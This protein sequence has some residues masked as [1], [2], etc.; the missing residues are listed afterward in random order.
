M[1]LFVYDWVERRIQLSAC[2]NLWLLVRSSSSSW[3]LFSRSPQILLVCNTVTWTLNS[4]LEFGF[5]V[6]FLLFVVFV[7]FVVA[8]LPSIHQSPV[9]G[10][11]CASTEAGRAVLVV[12]GCCFRVGGI[13]F[14]VRN[15]VQ[16]EIV[17]PISIDTLTVESEEWRSRNLIR[18]G[19]KGKESI[20]VSANGKHFGSVVVFVEWWFDQKEGG[21]LSVVSSAVLV[22]WLKTAAGTWALTTS[23][24]FSVLRTLLSSAK[25]LTN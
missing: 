13:H 20:E 15:I 23:I 17:A 21:L 10:K 22:H 16:K 25:G 3:I 19:R 12:G 14:K 18:G 5:G 11:A 9:E 7:H 8:L 2:C 4:S 1:V 6:L 24:S